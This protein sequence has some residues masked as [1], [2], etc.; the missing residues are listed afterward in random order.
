MSLSYD[1]PPA[2]TP[3]KT[4]FKI[5]YAIIAILL[6]TLIAFVAYFFISKANQVP[7]GF[8]PITEMDVIDQQAVPQEVQPAQAAPVGFAM[9]VGKF[10]GQAHPIVDILDGLKGF[11]YDESVAAAD[12]VYVVYDPR[13]PYCHSLYEK[14]EATD[15][16]NKQ[17]TIKWLPSLALGVTPEAEKLAAM[18]L[19]SKNKDVFA[20]SFKTGA[21]VSGVTVGQ[22]DQDALNENMAFLFEASN[23][24]FG[25][26]YPKSVP[27]VFFIDKK[28]GEPNM[29]Y[30]ASD[31]AVFK[32]IFGD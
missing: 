27:A 1:K 31:D 29:M 19:Q 17:I 24:T 21:D 25:E 8:T 3:K 16:K 10:A 26:D 18:A 23:Q 32:Q 14:L 15:L 13:C 11:K 30:G 22:S 9:A 20:A 5:E 4:A 7:E 12:T 2:T 28:T 6:T